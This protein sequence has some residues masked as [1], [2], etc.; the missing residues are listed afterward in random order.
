MNYNLDG[1]RLIP[2]KFVKYLEILIDS[3]LNWEYQREL[4]A[5]KLS[6]AIGMLAKIRHYICKDALCN[7]YFGIFSSLL[8]YKIN[9]SNV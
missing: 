5:R 1:K 3:H 2:S 6:H 8:K 9:S 4:L 7:I